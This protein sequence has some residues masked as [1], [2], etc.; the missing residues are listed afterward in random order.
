MTIIDDRNWKPIPGFEGLYSVS[1]DGLIRAEE[2][3]VFRS[4]GGYDMPQKIMKTPGDGK[5][6]ARF[7]AR[8]DG[9]AFHLFVHQCVALAFLG[10]RPKGHEVRHLDGNSQNNRLENLAYGTRSDNIRD[11]KR[12]GTFPIGKDRPGAKLTAEQAQDI[13]NSSDLAEDIAARFG[14]KVGTVYQ[15]RM[16]LTWAHSVKRA[17]DYRQRGERHPL[18]KFTVAD[19]LAIRASSASSRTLAAMYGADK[20]SIRNILLRRS[21]KHVS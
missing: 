19:V 21:W 14:I 10:P 20:A 15:I 6:Y 18:A 9:R 11:A 3:H 1:S 2:K 17:A 5:G 8:K 12:H 16:G 4:T 7:N 13:A